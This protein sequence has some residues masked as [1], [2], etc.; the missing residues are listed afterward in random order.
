M[1]QEDW[2]AQVS[3]IRPAASADAVSIAAAIRHSVERRMPS[4]RFGIL[5]SGGVDSSLIAYI[6][7]KEDMICYSVGMEGSADLAAAMDASK[8]LSLPLKTRTFSLSEAESLFNTTARIMGEANNVVNMGVGAVEVACLQMGREDG[9][10]I[11]MGGL[12]SEEIFAGYQRHE[13]AEDINKEC[14]SGLSCMWQRDLVRDSLISTSFGIEFRCPFL[15]KDLISLGMAVP[16]EEKIRDGVKKYILRQAAEQI[17]LPHDIAFR[18]KKAAQYGSSFDK[19]LQQV[20]KKNGFRF[21]SDY[22]RSLQEKYK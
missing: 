18:P 10:D 2:A 4:K 16:A 5:F 1:P 19:A 17:G 20:A 3:S 22:I 8:R 21:K 12:G 14:W 9:I 7:R 11:Y 15:D 13:E 6:C